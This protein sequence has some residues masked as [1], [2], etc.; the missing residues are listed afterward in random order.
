MPMPL[1]RRK[2]RREEGATRVSGNFGFM[3]DGADS[4]PT[5]GFLQVFDHQAGAARRFWSALFLANRAGGTA[6]SERSV[7]VRADSRAGRPR[8]CRA[9]RRRA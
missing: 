7:V 5:G 8:P 6:R 2:S 9:L 4:L 3:G 1:R